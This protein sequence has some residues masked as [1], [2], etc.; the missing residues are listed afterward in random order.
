MV[1]TV[2]WGLIGASTIARE[3]MVD[4]IRKHPSGKVKA[5]VSSD[6]DRARAFASDK[7]IAASYAS[8]EAMLADPE[9][10]AVYISRTNDRHVP[11]AL[12]A[13]EAG[14]HVLCE[15]PLALEIAD[16]QKIVDAARNKGVVLATNHHLRNMESHRAI[17]SLIDQGAIGKVN[18]IRVFHAGELPDSL[19]T[20]RLHDKAAGG[21]VIYD[22]TV[23]NGDLLRFYLGANPI[24]IAAIAA[25]SGTGP[26]RIE[27]SVMSVWEFPGDILVQ[28]HDSFVVGHGPR[29]VEIH[30]SQG[31]ILG[32]DVMS[33]APGGRVILR[34][35]DG[36][37]EI[38]LELKVTYDRGIS[39]FIAAIQ[40]RGK[41]SSSGD[42]GVWS[43]KLAKAVAE[44][45]ATGRTISIE[46]T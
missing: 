36:D 38:P 25:T 30:G 6:L 11:D 43:L 34:T 35:K 19:K 27:D 24:R 13:I 41:P 21:G 29:G 23:H 20:W 2:V 42:D 46:Q 18:S 39:D 16:A 5:I 44:S 10:T 4:S 22:I 33:Q 7:A 14:K 26:K 1:D 3:W 45:A 12:A 32:I 37:R 9:I 17:K 40:N 8:V 15:K 28:C 31:S